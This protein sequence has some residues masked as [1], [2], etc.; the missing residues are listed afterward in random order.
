[1]EDGVSCHSTS[2][3]WGCHNPWCQ[4]ARYCVSPLLEQNFWPGIW[5]DFRVKNGNGWRFSLFNMSYVDAYRWRRRFWRHW[6]GVLRALCGR[7]SA[8]LDCQYRHV[9]TFACL[10]NWMTQHLLY[11]APIQS[12]EGWQQ[13]LTGWPQLRVSIECNKPPGFQFYIQ[14]NLIYSLEGMVDLNMKLGRVLVG[15][16]LTQMTDLASVEFEIKW[17]KILNW[18]TSDGGKR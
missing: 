8:N 16:S 11:P 18:E 2:P 1:M 10:V 4:A 15:L 3:M 14:W 9:K 7:I 12:F 13:E 6:H 5:L 17:R